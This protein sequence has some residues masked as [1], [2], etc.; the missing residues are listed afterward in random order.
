MRRAVLLSSVVI[1]AAA[2]GCPDPEVV[3][4][5]RTAVEHGADL[6]QDPTLG[7]SNNQQTCATCHAEHRSTRPHAP[8]APLSGAT[9]RPSYWGGAEPTLLGAI[10]ACRY[11]FMLADTPW[12]GDEIEARAIYAYLDAIEAEP[13]DQEAAPLT[14]GDVTVPLVGDAS[15]GAETYQHACAGCHGARTSALGRT[16]GRAPTLPDATLAQH[17]LGEYTEEERLLVFVEKVRHGGFLGYGGQMPP[18]SVETLSDQ[19]LADVL[20]YLGLP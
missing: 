1:A 16:I 11:Y 2:I 6:I 7:G 9:S 8:G 10:N 12:T 13:A 3:T 20:A 15:S 19:E 18:L 5:Q 4:E 14:I 17:P